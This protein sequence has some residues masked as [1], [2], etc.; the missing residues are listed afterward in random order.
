MRSLRAVALMLLFTVSLGGCYATTTTAT[1]HYAPAEGQWGR[2][3][4]VAFVREVVHRQ[5]GDPAGGAVAGAIIGGLLGGG[6]GGGAV[7]GAIGGAVI[8]ASVSQGT[9]ESRVYEVGVRF[10]DGGFETYGYQGY[11]PF[12]PGQPVVLTPQGLAGR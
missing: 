6:R 1:T 2:P 7:L 10:E 12:S 8:G 11:A 3:G 9:T 4:A 5:H